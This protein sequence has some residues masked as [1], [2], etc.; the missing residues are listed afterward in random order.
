MKTISILAAAA[1]A[2][3][4]AFA[5]APAG[6]VMRPAA[7]ANAAKSGGMPAE[8]AEMKKDGKTMGSGPSANWKAMDANGDGMVSQEEYMAYHTN[9]WK[10]M[11]MTKGNMISM[12]DMEAQMAS[13][14][15]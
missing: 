10:K 13:G 6:T 8:K 2:S 3:A 1:I 5:Q 14:P 15:N 4:S 7:E 9:N 11:K 12:Q